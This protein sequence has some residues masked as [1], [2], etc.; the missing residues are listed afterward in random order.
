MQEPRG[1]L[2]SLKLNF[3]LFEA[4]I[5]Y[6]LN[7]LWKA[8][9][10]SPFGGGLLPEPSPASSFFPEARAISNRARLR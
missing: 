1:G 4:L 8:R 10:S 6:L 3:P 9:R 5:D 2:P 7:E